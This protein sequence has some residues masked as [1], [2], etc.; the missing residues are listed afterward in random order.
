MPYKGHFLLKNMNYK[1]LFDKISFAYSTAD[2]GEKKEKFLALKNFKKSFLMFFEEIGEQIPVIK[3][4]TLTGVKAGFQNGFQKI[5]NLNFPKVKFGKKT[6]KVCLFLLLILLVITG[7]SKIIKRYVSSFKKS[8]ITEVKGARAA[9]DVN[10]EF[11]FPLKDAKGE[12]VSKIKYVVEKA[13]L[14]DEIIVQGQKATAVKGRTFLIITLKISNEH[15]QPIEINTRD[16]LRLSVNS[17]ENELLAPDIH[18]DPAEV[19]AI[20]TKYTRVGFPINT[21]DN[22]LVLFVG[23]IN[24]AKEKIELKLN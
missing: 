20:S 23:E 18:N 24:G 21:S 5:K 6:V 2:G 7:G 14:R 19:Q 3:T 22:N 16:Y 4:N 1:G 17:N 13:E 8:G 12:E 11:N 10:K 9:Q 15:N